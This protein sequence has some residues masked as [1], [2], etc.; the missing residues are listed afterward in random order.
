MAHL[1]SPAA[2]RVAIVDD[3]PAV[4]ASLRFT[5]EIEG[6]VVD[7]FSSAEQL[8]S[9]GI[10]PSWQCLIL[11]NLLPGGMTGLDLLD[12]LRAMGVTTPAVLIAT[13]FGPSVAAQAMRA[14]IPFVDKPLLGTAIVDAVHRAVGQR[15]NPPAANSSQE[16]T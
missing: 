14:G 7:A 13:H 5:L 1:P 16:E 15:G 9:A 11:D 2:L 12:H 10:R 3:D 6:Y 8:L 4:L